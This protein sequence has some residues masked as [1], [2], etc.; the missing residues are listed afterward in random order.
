MSK[1]EIAWPPHPDLDAKIRR[2]AAWW[3]SEEDAL[4][5][6]H[7]IDT[8]ITRRGG[9]LVSI[10]RRFWDAPKTDSA[11]ETRMHVPVAADI[12]QYSARLTFGQPLIITAP[13]TA[14]EPV[15]A[16]QAWLW[17]AVGAQSVC[18]EAAE[19][20]SAMT[21]AYVRVVVDQ[22]TAPDRPI[23]SVVDPLHADPDFNW[24]GTLRSVAFVQR[25]PSKPGHPVYRHKEIHT[26]GRVEHE[27][28]EGT[29][30]TLGRM[31][32][33]LAHPAT[34]DLDVDENNGYDTGCPDALTAIYVP[35]VTP[36]RGS[37]RE[38]P[39]GRFYGR[40]DY[41]GVES[42]FASVD[43][44]WTNVMKEMRTGR[45]R[46]F[47]PETTLK[48]GAPGEGATFDEDQDFFVKVPTPH[49][50]DSS[51]TTFAPPLRTAEILA[52]YERA[53]KNAYMFAGFA[54]ASFGLT[55]MVAMTATQSRALEKRTISTH[56]A[57]T[58]EWVERLP[59]LMYA[60]M[61]LDSL[62]FRD[63]GAVGA[64]RSTFEFPPAIPE[65]AA[66]IAGSVQMLRQAELIS[67]EEGVRQINPGKDDDWI[68]AEAAK[69][70]G[71]M[72]RLVDPLDVQPV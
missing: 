14:P 24:D 49:A 37:W 6:E 20:Q 47:I 69:I 17:G 29:E 28:W 16:R 60:T 8:A 39:I 53:L 55:D 61:C 27:L 7:G 18:L 13:E 22:T 43:E 48:V 19:V 11:A 2:L 62:Y 31:V 54:P 38:H 41:E 42:M 59:E 1:P 35:N 21:A 51:I 36:A 34:S 45:M 23:W 44:A 3:S 26:L 10:W 56:A 64:I 52:V 57:K 9:R 4:T 32:D 71:N 15:V 30:A 63:K 68:M 40:S 5:R 65:T 50:A 12:S 67:I 58:S 25:F 66:D 46:G 70:A 72:G 33:L